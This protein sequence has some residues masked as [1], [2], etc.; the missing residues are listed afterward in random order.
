MSM[1][2]DVK[3]GACQCC[4]GGSMSVMCRWE[5]VSDL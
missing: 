1:I 2:S 5:Y 3:V 4:V